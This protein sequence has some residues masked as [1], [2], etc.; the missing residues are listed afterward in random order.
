MFLL[1]PTTFTSCHSHRWWSRGADGTKEGCG[2]SKQ[3]QH[4][5]HP[6]VSPSRSHPTTLPI[7]PSP[8]LLY[9]LLAPKAP[10]K[11][12]PCKG[13]SPGLQPP[14]G[15]AWPEDQADILSAK[16]SWKAQQQWMFCI[17]KAFASS[18]VYS[19][20][21]VLKANSVILYLC[22]SLLLQQVGPLTAANG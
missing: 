18:A 22:E 4:T 1:H 10:K 21:H 9:R 11:S 15:A 19:S 12:V 13:L 14:C 6:L 20:T 2:P 5:M 16:T 3:G 17:R 8:C 7:F